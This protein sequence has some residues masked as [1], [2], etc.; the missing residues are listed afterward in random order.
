MTCSF[1]NLLQHLSKY[2]IVDKCL[3]NSINI[4]VTLGL[5]KYN[6][7]TRVSALNK[8]E[9]GLIQLTA[10]LIH[11]MYNSIIAIDGNIIKGNASIKT[12]L[13]EATKY[14]TIVI[15]ETEEE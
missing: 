13:K 1:D 2:D 12:M 6:F 3:L 15:T 8:G 9:Q 11:P 10:Y 4:L 7:F 14:C 5:G